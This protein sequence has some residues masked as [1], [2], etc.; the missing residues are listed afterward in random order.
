MYF[1]GEKIYSFLIEPN[2]GGSSILLF[3]ISLLLLNFIYYFYSEYFLRTGSTDFDF[4]GR[5]GRYL[6]FGRLFY[7]FLLSRALL[8][9][10][11]KT[12]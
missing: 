10:K 9:L 7:V 3:N 4:I 1:I 6:E 11:V 8:N 2:I 5:E 12:Y